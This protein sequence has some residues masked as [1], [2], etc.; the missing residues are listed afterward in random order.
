MF[1]RH[2]PPRGL[3]AGSEGGQRAGTGLRA[4]R[5]RGRAGTPLGSGPRAAWSQLPSSSEAR[6]AASPPWTRCSEAPVP[7]PLPGVGRP[8]CH[9]R[10]LGDVNIRSLVWHRS[11]PAQR[12][13]RPPSTQAGAPMRGIPGRLQVVFCFPGGDS[14]PGRCSLPTSASCPRHGD[15]RLHPR[16]ADGGFSLPARLGRA[17]RRF[18]PQF[19]S[20]FIP[21]R[22]L[23][24]FPCLAGVSHADVDS[25]RRYL[26]EVP[27]RVLRMN[28]Q[29]RGGRPGRQLR[30]RLV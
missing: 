28:T 8:R 7:G 2:C 15:L 11:V 4:G 10:L 16:A 9:P 12:P 6:L 3:W 1:P 25:G 17:P 26:C 13:G 18:P 27:L 5:G 20:P 21:G 30:F 22:T 19:L 14:V 24:S 23:R 29:E